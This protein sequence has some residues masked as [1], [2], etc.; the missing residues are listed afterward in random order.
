MFYFIGVARLAGN[1]HAT[2]V[3]GQNLEKLF[4]Q[5]PKD[6]G[7]YM[8][9]VDQFVYD[10]TL[11]KRK[12]IPWTMLMLLLGSLGFLMGGA[13]DTGLVS[14]VTHVGIIY[15]FIASML[16]GFIKQWTYLGRNHRLLRQLKALF[17]LP[18][19]QM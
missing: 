10:S 16:L 17:G 4:D 9:K 2:L 14:R 6:L 13:Y 18:D 8:K 5:V 15:G 11:G 1:V 7:P 3:G 12:T 19:H